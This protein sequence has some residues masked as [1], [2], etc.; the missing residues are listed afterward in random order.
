MDQ[1]HV[2]DGG[3]DG[4]GSTAEDNPLFAVRGIFIP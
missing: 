4:D 2:Y 1:V 3:S